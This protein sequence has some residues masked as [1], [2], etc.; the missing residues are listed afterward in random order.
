MTRA[1]LL[2]LVGMPVAV[3]LFVVAVVAIQTRAPSMFWPFIVAIVVATA[4]VNARGPLT[5]A[6]SSKQADGVM[7]AAARA[8]FAVHIALKGFLP[9]LLGL[10][11]TVE[12]AK[13][14]APHARAWLQ[15]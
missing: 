5:P 12:M 4:W 11:L 15:G 7:G 6:A 3:N 9:A 14:L 10:F 2:A 13:W 8:R 1:L